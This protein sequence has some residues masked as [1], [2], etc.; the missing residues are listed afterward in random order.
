MTGEISY[1]L[2]MKDDMG[3]V[4]GTYRLPNGEWQVFIVNKAHVQQVEL[5]PSQ[6]PSGVTGVVA[7]APDSVGLNKEAV[8]NLMSQWLKV[9]NW[10]EVQ[11]PDSMQL[12]V[13]S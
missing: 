11:G 12:Q 4:E 1:D 2:V 9:D 7:R 8:E 10:T 6:W 5:K 13:L 3:F